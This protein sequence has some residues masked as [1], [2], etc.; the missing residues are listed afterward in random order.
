MN[1]L[2]LLNDLENQEYSENSEEF[3]NNDVSKSSDEQ[4]RY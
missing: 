4:M 1:N 2:V 3:S